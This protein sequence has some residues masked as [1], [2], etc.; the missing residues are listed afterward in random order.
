MDNMYIGSSWNVNDRN[1]Y[2]ERNVSIDHNL[3]NYSSSINKMT[4]FGNS[5]RPK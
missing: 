1:T 4:L 5:S 2:I 3:A